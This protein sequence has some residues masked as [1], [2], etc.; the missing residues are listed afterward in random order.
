MLGLPS[1]SSIICTVFIIFCLCYGV[2]LYYVSYL[3]LGSNNTTLKT[4]TENNAKLKDGVVASE[5]LVTNDEFVRRS[6][7]LRAAENS[8][9][10][11]VSRTTDAVTP[12]P[13]IHEKVE[14]V[15]DNDID[16]VTDIVECSTT[17][18]NITIDVRSRWG[19]L[20]SA[21][22]LS[23]VEHNFFDDLPFFR[24][25][26]RYITQFGVKYQTDE[27]KKNMPK[28]PPILDDPSLYGKRDMDFG[29]IFFAGSG[30]NSR[31]VQ[32]VVALC[33]MAGCVV[34]TLG[35]A[36]WEVPIATIR[37]ENFEVL[38]EIAKSGFPYPKLEMKGQHPDASGPNQ[39][40]IRNIKD[41]LKDEY[42]QM[43]FWKGC[44]RVT[45]PNTYVAS[46]P[47]SVDHPDSKQRAAPSSFKPS[48]EPVNTLKN[49]QFIELFIAHGSPNVNSQQQ[50]DKLTVEVM[51]TWSPIGAS[52][53]IDIVS[54]PEF[55]NVSLFRVIK[56]MRHSY[57]SH[58]YTSSWH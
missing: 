14:A 27:D 32:M 30:S 53:L 52:R 51:P 10:L 23:M 16:A 11:T 39:G 31:A 3:H 5:N 9:Q 25:C 4:S 40:K 28:F 50:L 57:I 43:Q 6:A 20:G 49:S 24:V 48:K 55:R 13:I 18:G 56:V 22:F 34:S 29:Y 58:S 17:Q 37:K 1:M 19:P 41:Y 54:L 33:P 46:R 45:A 21:R 7:S 15:P 36:K 12:H 2:L 26:P 8:P 44:H 35:H 42:P 47:L 38:L